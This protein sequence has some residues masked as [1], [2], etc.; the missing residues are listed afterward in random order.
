MDKLLKYLTKLKELEESD[1]IDK[2][3]EQ[4]YIPKI[5]YYYDLV[6]EGMKNSTI[7]TSEIINDI[8]SLKSYNWVQIDENISNQ[9]KSCKNNPEYQ[10]IMKL[11]RQMIEILKKYDDDLV[12]NI[13][14]I[15]PDNSV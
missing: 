14:T 2:N 4:I 10:K 12:R 6:G 8:N 15:P 11:R 13:V 3:K 5:N 9:Y 1:Y 7:Y